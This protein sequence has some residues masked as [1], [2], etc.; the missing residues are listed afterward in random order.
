MPRACR[1]GFTLIEVTVALA[2]FALCI[3]ALYEEFG[4]ALRRSERVRDREQALLFAQSRLAQLRV[5]PAPWA[6]STSGRS[7]DG[8]WWREDVA[9]FDAG[10][11]TRNPWKAFA[12]TV[13]VRRDAGGAREVALKS[14]ELAR[15]AP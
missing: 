1:T 5:S 13:R 7:T 6:A 14:V 11:D 10:A 3:G 9:P 12:V 2:I 8:W 4:G 15:T